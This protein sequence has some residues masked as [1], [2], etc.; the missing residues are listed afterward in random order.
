VASS[1]LR[2]IAGLKGDYSTWDRLERD[3]NPLQG[4]KH[5]ERAFWLAVQERYPEAVKALEDSGPAPDTAIGGLG[6]SLLSGSQLLPALLRAYRATGRGQEADAM[7]QKY[8]G[9]LRQDPDADLD[10]AALAANE[11]LKDEAVRALQRLFD[12]FPLVDFFHPKLPWFR[13][14]EGHPGFDGLMAERGRRIARARAEM[15]QLEADAGSTAR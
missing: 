6:S 14:L 4:S 1:L 3:A 9:K 7:A 11:G 10:L 2:E 13:S 5:F 15:L 12:R 8:L